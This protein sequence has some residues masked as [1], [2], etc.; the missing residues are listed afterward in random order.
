VPPRFLLCLL[1][2]AA[3]P[4]LAAE[5]GNEHAKS[6]LERDVLLGDLG[7]SRTA[8]EDRGVTASLQYT[9]E[10]LGVVSG[11]IA[12]RGESTGLVQLDLDLDLEKLVGWQG[13]LL[14]ATGYIGWGNS[15]S[16]RWIGDESNISNINMRNGARLFEAYLQQSFGDLLSIRAGLLA[17]DSEFYSSSVESTRSRGGSLFV[18]SDFGAMPIMSFNVPEPIFP[19]STPGVSVTVHATDS[20][21]FRTAIYSGQP[22]PAD[23]FDDRNAHGFSPRLSTTDGA[24]VMAEIEYEVN[25]PHDPPAEPGSGSGKE[26][27]AVAAPRGLGGCYRLGG[28]YHTT[29][30]TDWRSGR[31]VQ[32]LGG[33]WL[34]ANQMVW[35]E[36]PTDDQG[37]SLFA[38]VSAAPRDRSVLEFCTD[39]GLHYHGLIPGRDE[40]DLGLGVSMKRYSRDFSRSEQFAANARRDHETIIELSYSVPVTPW[41]TLQ[42][43]VQYILHPA[44][45]RTAENALVAG[46]RVAMSF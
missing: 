38:R 7:G 26:A 10:Y 17:N 1:G 25:Q 30:F 15:I 39:A 44:G 43:D 3:A 42:P 21:I 32:G 35:R 12:R 22:L 28:F 19:I 40:D 34:S 8:A 23:A 11:G 37:L 13:G 16:A 45:D 36:N 14:H 29:D 31:T 9:Q 46:V 18:N 2:L 5:G 27:K 6:L 20:L 41:L 24:L 33:G 4:A